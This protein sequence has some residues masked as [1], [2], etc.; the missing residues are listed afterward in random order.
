MTG[1]VLQEI[2]RI[3]NCMS[4][5][6]FGDCFGDMGDYLWE[7]FDGKEFDVFNFV[8]YLDPGN[9]QKLVNYAT[10]KMSIDILSWTEKSW[11]E[12]QKRQQAIFNK[13]ITERIEALPV[14]KKFIVRRLQDVQITSGDSLDSSGFGIPPR[15]LGKWEFDTIEEALVFYNE[16]KAAATTGGLKGEYFSYPE[17]VRGKL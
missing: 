17:P 2:L 9:A 1:V 15:K 10:S 4:R 12:E 16:R 8:C 14:P 11:I 3:L 13:M 6:E 7:K 5:N